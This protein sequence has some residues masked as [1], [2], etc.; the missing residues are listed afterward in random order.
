[1]SQSDVTTPSPPK[2]TLTTLINGD[3]PGSLENVPSTAGQGEDL[4]DKELSGGTSHVTRGHARPGKVPCQFNKAGICSIHG[5][6]GK[7]KGRPTTVTHT[8]ADGTVTN[9]VTRR[10]F[11]TC[12]I[13][14]RERGQI[15]NYFKHVAKDESTS[16]QNNT[17][18]EGKNINCVK[19][20]KED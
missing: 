9:K 17:S 1:M 19:P 18:K 6:K 11:W 14:P 4:V 3:Y 5:V 8:A 16:I 15:T 20:G 13:G 10:Y 7:K 12:E 2:N